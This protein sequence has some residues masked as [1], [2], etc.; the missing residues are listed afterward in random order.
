MVAYADH[1]DFVSFRNNALVL[2]ETSFASCIAEHA[3]GYEASVMEFR[4]DVRFSKFFGKA[5][6]W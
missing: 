2:E 4:E 1:D 3:D 6:D 5:W